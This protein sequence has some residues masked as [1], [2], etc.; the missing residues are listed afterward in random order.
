MWKLEETG[1]DNL[2]DGF[3]EKYVHRAEKTNH[4]KVLKDIVEVEDLF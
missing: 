4:K 2:F 3:T 1:L